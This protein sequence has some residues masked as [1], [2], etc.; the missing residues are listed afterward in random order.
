MS[1]I[2]IPDPDYKR[3]R[4]RLHGELQTFSSADLNRCPLANRCF[5]AVEACHHR[6]QVLDEIEPGRWVACHRVSEG[7]I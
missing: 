3:P 5:Q 7:E 6:A 4:I 2:P 1:A